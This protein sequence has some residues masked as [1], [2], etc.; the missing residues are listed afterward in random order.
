MFI[1]SPI[2]LIQVKEDWKF[3]AMVLDRLFLWIF[4]VAVFVGTCGIILHAPTLYDNREPID[5][6]LSEVALAILN[7]RRGMQG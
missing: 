6:K 7:N 3:V 2:F 5:I 4:T 1:F